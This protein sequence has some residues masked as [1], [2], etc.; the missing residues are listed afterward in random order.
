MADSCDE[1]MTVVVSVMIKALRGGLDVP[2]A[3][4]YQQDSTS[5]IQ[6]NTAHSL[7]VDGTGPT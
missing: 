4:W 5:V 1:V 3:G 7:H 6:A 2:I